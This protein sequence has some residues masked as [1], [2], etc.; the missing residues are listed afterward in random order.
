MSKMLPRGAKALLI[1]LQTPAPKGYTGIP[2]LVWGRPGEGKSSFLE[3]LAR[4]DFPVLTLIASI[5]DPTDFSGLPVHHE[6]QVR[7]A[8]PE[9]VG[10]FTETGSGILLL[11]ELTTAPPAVQSALLRVVLERKVGFHPLPRQV[12]IVAAANPPDLMTGGWELSPP[13]RNRF[14]HIEWE[15]STD[16]YLE[17]LQNGYTEPELP[18]ISPASHAVAL[19]G[20]QLRVA[21][22]LKQA[23]QLMYTTPDTSEYAFASPRSWDFA[24]ALM[25]S[26]EVLGLAPIAGV[27]SSEV[28]HTLLK[29][30][31]GEGASIA[32][33]EFIYNMHLP[34]PDKVLDGHEKVQIEKLNDSEVYI[35]FGA[36]QNALQRRFEQ[37]ELVTSALRYFDLIRAVF[38]DGRRDLIYVSLKKATRNGLLTKTLAKSQAQRREDH[39]Q[40]LKAIQELF[41]DEG[42]NEFIN[43][44]EK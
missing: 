27:Q 21:A 40:V 32:F 39:P 30:S 10:Q 26:C 8:V 18:L 17:A 34:D 16:Y 13:L 15:L 37:P 12:R 28:F 5:H 42:L 11:D 38:K 6:G 36:L 22:F 41:S 44:F 29:G 14:V 31:I 4:P 7:Y 24:A 1:A 19:A 2:V 23:P 33:F 25:A 43:I 3:G 20:W 9:W 35:L